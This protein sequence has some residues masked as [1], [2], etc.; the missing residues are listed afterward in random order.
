MSLR[1]TLNFAIIACRCNSKKV[2]LKPDFVE[3]NKNQLILIYSKF[4][5]KFSPS[6]DPLTTP[7]AFFSGIFI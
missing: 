4:L 7:H 3:N 6:N 5:S 1:F 2:F